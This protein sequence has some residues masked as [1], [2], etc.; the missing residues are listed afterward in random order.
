MK[1]I[2]NEMT[3]VFGESILGHVINMSHGIGMRI[4][5]EGVETREQLERLRAIACDYVRGYY[6]AKP[7]PVDE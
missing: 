1:F 6:F 5:A 7:M 2:Q 4:V 3:R